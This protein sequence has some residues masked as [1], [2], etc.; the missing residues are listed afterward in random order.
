VRCEQYHRNYHG[1]ARKCVISLIPLCEL[2]QGEMQTVATRNGLATNSS[3]SKGWKVLP[4]SDS[5]PMPCLWPFVGIPS[6]A[7]RVRKTA[8]HW[9]ALIVLAAVPAT[10][11]QHPVPLDPKT[12]DAKCAECHSDLTQGKVVHPAIQMGCSSCHFVRGSGENT[13]VVLKTPKSTL[14]CTTCHADKKAENHG[15]RVHAPVARDCLQCHDPHHSANKALLKKVTSGGKDD[16]LCLKCHTQGVNVPEKGSRHAALDM[17]CD[18]C[19]ITHKT[20]DSG[21]EEFAFHLTK[22]VPALCVDCHDVKDRKLVEAH[23]GQPFA[24]AVCTNCHEPHQ[25][26]LP[27]LMQAYVHPPFADKTCEVCHEAA[28]GGKVKLTQAQVPALCSSCHDEVAKKIASA[29]FPHAG[30]QGDCTDCHD[31]HAGRYPRFVRPNPVAVCLGCHTDQAEALKTKN[32]THNPVSSQCSICHAPHGGENAKLLRAKDNDL[33]LECHGP[34][35]KGAK[36]PNS[37]KVSIFSGS[38][39][40]PSKYIERTTHLPLVSGKG[41]P[42]ARHPVSG[43]DPSNPAKQIT[44]LRCHV[45][46]AGDSHL[47]VTGGVNAAPLCSQCHAKP[48]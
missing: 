5:R 40:L 11:K 24:G 19:H 25:S 45:P 16:N 10:A 1:W 38:V 30:A 34:E 42:G 31:P 36:V 2:S 35:A 37:D 15:K 23:K 29:K 43:A 17:G 39:L 18:T 20:G 9:L 22:A 41:H 26:Q 12:D 13:R 4:G 6:I 48:K 28:Q 14:L 47:L 21:K 32:V 46:H 8:A 33:C 3:F 44:C 27:K 7:H